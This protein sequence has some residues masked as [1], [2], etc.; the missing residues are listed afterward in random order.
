MHAGEEDDSPEPAVSRRDYL[1]GQVF[2][3]DDLL[4]QESKAAQNQVGPFARRE[5]TTLVGAHGGHGKSTFCTRIVDAYVG[6]KEFLGFPGEGGTAVIIDL[7]QNM[8]SAQR[9][10][11][12]AMYPGR[13][14]RSTP[15]K[16]IVALLPRS[17]YGASLVYCLWPGG[18]DI[19]KPGVD[20]D[21]IGEVLD[22]CSAGLVM[23]DPVYKLM[24]GSP[25]K[26]SETI[27]GFINLW[28]KLRSQLGFGTLLPM[29]PRKP[30]PQ[31]GGSLTMHDL[32]G[33]AHWSWWG[34]QIFMLKRTPGTNAAVMRI[35]KDRESELNVGEEW[36][37]TFDPDR[38][39]E[40][41]ASD[42]GEGGG[43][44][45]AFEKVWRLLQ[46]PENAAKLFTRPDLSQM[47]GIPL[48]TVK[49]ADRILRKRWEAGRYPG[50]VFEAGD[51]GIMLIGYRPQAQ[52]ADL[53]RVMDEAFGAEVEDEDA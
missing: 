31:G 24:M 5:T 18:V 21:V 50:L 30:P 33:H 7:E 16:D 35:E 22:K 15:V 41:L 8:T 20:L 39:Y 25:S 52:F 53:D 43:P 42:I 10:V 51:R 9:Q 27:E 1:L 46:Q 11:M 14:E 26:E 28:G 34:E 37:L 38:G 13:W 4:L 49:K 47:L 36:T 29:H 2:T 3:A 19:S 40:R 32:Y 44:L 12:Q 17:E 45:P 23:L 48:D 6:E